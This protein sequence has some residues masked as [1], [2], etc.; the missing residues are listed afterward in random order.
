MST[1]PAPSIANM[2]ESAN[3]LAALIDTI[4]HAA[5]SPPHA[6]LELVGGFIGKGQPGSAMFKFGQSYGQV[7]GVL[8]A[9]EIPTTLIRPQAW[10]KALSLGNSTSHEKGKWKSHLATRAKQLYP[11]TKITLNTSDAVL[12]FHAAATERIKI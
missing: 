2:P 8:A 1:D 5:S 6:F 7:I 9:L 11:K 4:N 3:D 10:Q 12:I